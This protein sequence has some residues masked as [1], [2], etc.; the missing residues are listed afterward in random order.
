MGWHLVWQAT[1][2][3][4]NPREIVIMRIGV[5]HVAHHNV[6]EITRLDAGTADRRTRTVRTES[7]WRDPLQAATISTDRGPDCTDH[8]DVTYHRTST[9]SASH[10]LVGPSRPARAGE[11]QPGDIVVAVDHLFGHSDL[12]VDIGLAQHHDPLGLR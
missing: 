3:G 10:S 9:S 4:G 6:T 5:N 1:I 12:L 8:H 2:D 7:A 11:R